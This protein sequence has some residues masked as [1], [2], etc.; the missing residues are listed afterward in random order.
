MLGLTLEESATASG[1]PVA[2]VSDCESDGV[3]PVEDSALRTLRR[4][5]EAKGVVFVKD[6]DDTSGG[7]GVRFAARDQVAQTMRPENL[8]AANDD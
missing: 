1:L 2:V 4:S 3:A 6:G 8:N 5:Y 7:A